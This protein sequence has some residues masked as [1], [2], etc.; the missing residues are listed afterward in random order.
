MLLNILA[1]YRFYKTKEHEFR[2]L[3]FMISVKSREFELMDQYLIHTANSAF[4]STPEAAEAI[5]DGMGYPVAVK[6][7]SPGIHKTDVGGV[8]LNVNK[9]NVRT[10]FNEVVEN[11]KKAGISY[12]GCIIQKMAPP[13]LEVIVGL[14]QDPQFGPV[15][16]FGMGG[17]YTEILKDFSLRVCPITEQD[18]FEMVDELKSHE[19]FKSRGK[20]Y[21]KTAIAGLLMKVNN[22]A[23]KEKI[24]E[25]DLNPVFIYPKGN[26]EEYIVVDVRL[27][28]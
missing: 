6:I 4:A 7:Q 21:D 13:G 5:A 23:M 12:S 25:L 24:K 1:T 27:I 10:A 3:G 9:E 14:K 18:A 11:A 26:E 15:I 2:E 20:V 17:I 19:I 8:R 22:I 16:L 28:E